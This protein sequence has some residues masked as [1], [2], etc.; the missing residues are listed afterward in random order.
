MFVLIGTKC[1]GIDLVF[2]NHA[3]V[4]LYRLCVI[5]KSKD[6]ISS[7]TCYSI[8]DLSFYPSVCQMFNLI[9]TL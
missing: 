8:F 9:S 2:R 7:L 1:S 3:R 4:L 5:C 6:F